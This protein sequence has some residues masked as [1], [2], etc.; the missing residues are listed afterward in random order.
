MPSLKSSVDFKVLPSSSLL[1]NQN[2]RVK[3]QYL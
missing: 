1:I 2:L 3:D